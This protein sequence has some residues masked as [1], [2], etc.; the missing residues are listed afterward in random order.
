MACSDCW[1]VGGIGLTVGVGRR[2]DVSRKE[3]SAGDIV[4]LTVG[5]ERLTVRVERLI[6]VSRKVSSAGDIVGLTVGV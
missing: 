6:N 1:C 4:G 5:V 2:N 3:S